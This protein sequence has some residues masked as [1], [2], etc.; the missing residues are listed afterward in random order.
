MGN[1]G[2]WL[3]EPTALP[4]HCL[5]WSHPSLGRKEGLM[6]FP[7]PQYQDSDGFQISV[8]WNNV[9]WAL[10]LPPAL[11]FLGE[12]ACLACSDKY[13][14]SLSFSLWVCLKG[15]NLCRGVSS[16]SVTCGLCGPVRAGSGGEGLAGPGGHPLG[17]HREAF[18]RSSSAFHP[19]PAAWHSRGDAP[20][21]FLPASPH[22]AG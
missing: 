5:A 20:V 13:W 16:L 10:G 11:T 2:P 17:C 21:T 15:I 3:G 18:M 19:V 4:P 9:L 14:L 22:Q 8:C 7:L 12:P 6:N 1:D